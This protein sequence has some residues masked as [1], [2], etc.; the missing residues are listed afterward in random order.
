MLVV[1]A[2]APVRAQDR[3][4]RDISG[5][6]PPAEPTSEIEPRLPTP[7]EGYVTQVR[8]GTEWTFPASATSVVH[9]LQATH[10]DAWQRISDDLGGPVDN[11]VVIRVALDP[12]EMRALAPIGHPPPDYAT[13]VAY[14]H[15]GLILL[16]LEA[17][18]AWD[19][20]DASRVLTHELSHLALHRAVDGRSLPRWFVE[21][22][23]V[24]Q[25]GE[26]N[27]ART[28]TLWQAVVAG[29]VVPLDQLDDRFP[30]H[31]HRVN[32]AYAESADFVAHLRKD[33]PTGR[34]FRALLEHVRDGDSF[35][36]AT[37]AAYGATLPTLERE[38]R[39]RLEERFQTVPL[40]VSGGGLW[41][42][43]SLLLVFAYVR[44][45]RQHRAALARL[46]AEETA[47]RRAL[48]RAEQAVADEL[49]RRDEPLLVVPAD[50]SQR[51]PDI[52]TVEYE[53]RNHTLH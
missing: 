33:D 10:A 34:R 50:P 2:T 15:F 11:R 30:T 9:D 51:E 5:W 6:E 52:P 44:R 28:R 29:N 22:I 42:L 27:L 3:I 25:A 48:E 38:W 46:D 1:L 47:E 8:G 21:G 7:P 43:A 40:L 41:F 24:Y 18:D 32:V 23:A 26:N 20:P 14:P 12:E 16:S 17:P 53:G 35:E 36:D 31:P 19:P 39:A 45:R 4:P 13:G 37:F 49:A